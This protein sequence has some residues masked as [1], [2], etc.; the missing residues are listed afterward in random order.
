MLITMARLNNLKHLELMGVDGSRFRVA[1]TLG[2]GVNDRRY[3]GLKSGAF[4]EYF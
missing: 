1:Q 2:S 3:R 4:L